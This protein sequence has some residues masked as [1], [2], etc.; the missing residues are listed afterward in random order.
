MMTG[1]LIVDFAPHVPGASSQPAH[2]GAM[3]AGRTLTGLRDMPCFLGHMTCGCHMPQDTAGELLHRGPQPEPQ[4][5]GS[6]Q[7]SGFKGM[8]A[9]LHAAVFGATGRHD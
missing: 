9:M 5:V 2:L 4:P 1:S 3:H 7:I 6:P 8:R